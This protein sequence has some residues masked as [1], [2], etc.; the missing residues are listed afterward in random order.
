MRS[1]P[2]RRPT[3][4]EGAIRVAIRVQPSVIADE[5]GSARRSK[6]GRVPFQSN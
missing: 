5:P 6:V 2:G 3:A 1:L 4:P